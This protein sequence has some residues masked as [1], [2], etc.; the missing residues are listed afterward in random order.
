MMKTRDDEFD[1]DDEDAF[2]RQRERKKRKKRNARVENG[3]WLS[4][5]SGAKRGRVNA[6]TIERRPR[7]RTT[8][9]VY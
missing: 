8:L 4:S 5:S 3:W 2:W 9:L 1:R 7:G 6:R